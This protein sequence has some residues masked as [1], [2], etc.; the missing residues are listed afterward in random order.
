MS[1]NQQQ[2]ALNYFNSHA[3]NWRAKAEGAFETLVNV[4]E[5]RNDF[6]VAVAKEMSSCRTFLDAGCGTGEL[7]CE[8]AQLD[9]ESVGVDYAPEMIQLAQ[10]LAAERGLENAKFECSSIL[11]YEMLPDHYDLIGA[12]GFIEY[13][14]Q[15]DLFLFFDQVAAALVKGGSFVF[16][17]RNRLFNLASMNKYTLHEVKSGAVDALIGE[18]VAWT[19]AESVHDPLSLAPAPFEDDKIQ[20][21]NTGID[22]NTRFQYTP[23]QL[24]H[25]LAERGLRVRE[26]YPVHI[27]GVPPVFKDARPD[28]HV[29]IANLLQTSARHRLEL[30]GHS[31]TFMLHVQ[32]S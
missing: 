7:V 22:V 29:P 24:I 8:I 14:S 12:N 10:K 4:I 20:H 6:I 23:L 2:E 19:Q 17:S 25:L 9:T 18:A 32:K 11:E 5:Q 13:I 1:D 31:S 28:I 21:D 3:D 15:P 30:L 16:G 26:V 27:H